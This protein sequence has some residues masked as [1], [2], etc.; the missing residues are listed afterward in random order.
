ML[1]PPSVFLIFPS[2][3]QYKIKLGKCNSKRWESSHRKTNRKKT[4]HTTGRRKFSKIS[5]VTIQSRVFK[6]KHIHLLNITENIFDGKKYQWNYFV[7]LSWAVTQSLRFIQFSACLSALTS[8]SSPKEALH[9]C[10]H[11]TGRTW[12]RDSNTCSITAEQIPVLSALP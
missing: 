2:I 1:C 3:K 4:N 9:Q 12:A 11:D 6:S 8:Q 10:T 5:G 7:S